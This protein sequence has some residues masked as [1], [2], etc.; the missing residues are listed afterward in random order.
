MFNTQLIRLIT[1]HSDA[2]L[3]QLQ[4]LFGKISTES[5]FTSSQVTPK[6]FLLTHCYSTLFI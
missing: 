4:T 3:F 5:I 1:A 2:Y 6:R